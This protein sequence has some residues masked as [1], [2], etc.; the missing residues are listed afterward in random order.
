MT[1]Y[2]WEGP[3]GWT[4]S[5]QD[6]TRPN[7]TTGMAGTYTL[8]VTDTHGCTDTA[9]TDVTVN[10]KPDADAGDDKEICEGESTEIGGDPTCSGGTPPYTCGWSPTTGLDD[11]TKCNPTAS[12]TST[13]TYCVTCTDSKECTDTDC[14]VLTVYEKPKAKPG[15]DQIKCKA[16]GVTTFALSGSASGG[17][18]PYTYEWSSD[19]RCVNIKNPN[20]KDTDVDISCIGS[21]PVTLTVTDDNDCQDTDQVMLTVVTVTATASSDPP[22]CEGETICLYGGPDGMDSYYWKG[23][24]CWESYEQNPCRENAK[25][26]MSGTYTLTITKTCFAN[27][28]TTMDSY[29]WTGPRGFRGTERNSTPPNAT[30]AKGETYTPTV[31]DV[32]IS[33]KLYLPLVAKNYPPCVVCTD[34]ATTT[35]TVNPN[36]KARAGD[37]EEIC[38]GGSTQIGGDPTCK[39]GTP[40]CTCS[41]SPTTGLDDPTKCNPTASPDSTTTYCVTCTDFK[42]CTDTDCMTV[43]VNPNPKATACSNSPV[44]EGG[45]IKL[46][47][48]ASG[49]TPPYI[50]YCWT[51]PDGWT[52]CEQNPRRDNADPSMAGTYTLTV[53]DK[54]LCTDTATIE[55][56]VV[57]C[58]CEQILCNWNFENRWSWIIPNTPRPAYY[59]TAVVHSGS[60]AMHLGITSQSDVYSFSS[61]YQQLTI[62][63]DAET[64]TLSF[65][66]YPICHDTFPSDWQTVV[67]YDPNWQFLAYAMPKVCSNDQ[68]WKQHTFDLT[69]YKG[70]TIILYFNVYNN[71]VGNRKTAMYLDDASVQVCYLP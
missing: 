46:W 22:V 59:S 57:P 32:T 23:P 45:T 39:D 33:T 42:G 54:K 66:Y 2:S 6:P 52:R 8:T 34:T 15:P 3:G 65:W 63:G 30:T 47:G 14:M 64:V 55:V 38:E 67:I 26:S 44:C 5:L 48:S 53:T 40:P 29:S 28:V 19:D 69:P 50:S 49:G 71:G 18:E 12:P 16:N 37:D 4:S 43:T 61:I 25:P 20:S 27:T 36:P 11:P 56:D 60:W 13:T 17:T 7:A 10:A 68:T 62:P 1:S 41:W 21:Y 24:D 70:R 31:A 58:I 51:G 35:V 9:T